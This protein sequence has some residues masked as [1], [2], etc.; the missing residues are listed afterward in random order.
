MKI[1][2]FGVAMISEHV[3]VIFEFATEIKEENSSI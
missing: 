2:V 1:K 3:K